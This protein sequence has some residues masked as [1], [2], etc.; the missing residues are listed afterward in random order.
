MLYGSGAT[1]IGV[2][3]AR[4]VKRDAESAQRLAL[5]AREA[6]Q[7]LTAICE[8]KPELVQP[9]AQR[10]REWPVIKEKGSALSANEQRLFDGIQLGQAD[11]MELGGK[12]AKWIW[13]DAAKI[14][15]SLLVYI[16]NARNSTADSMINLG[17][18][19]KIERRNIWRVPA[20]RHDAFGEYSEAAPKKHKLPCRNH[21]ISGAAV[22]G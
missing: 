18:F 22:T 13:D 19:G 16:R 10:G 3:A 11:F 17:T 8:A 6:T 15:Y 1:I 7:M 12:S 2:L 14:A 21:L 9:L 20:H 5:L 4:S